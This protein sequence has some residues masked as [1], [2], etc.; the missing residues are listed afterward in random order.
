MKRNYISP[1]TEQ[2]ATSGQGLLMTVSGSVGDQLDKNPTDPEEGE[3]M[4][5]KPEFP[6]ND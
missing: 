5:V 4:G 3:E 1:A 6:W 2:F